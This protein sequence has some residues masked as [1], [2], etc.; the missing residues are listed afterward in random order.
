MVGWFGRLRRQEDHGA[1]LVEAAVVMPLLLMLTLG[2]WTTARAWNVHNVLDHAA[3]EAA[4][5]GAPTADPFS[6]LGT[7]EGEILAAR[8][9]WSLVD[10]CA[11]TIKG[12]SPDASARATGGATVQ[13]GSATACIGAVEDPTTDNRMQ[14]TVEIP[15]YRLDFLFFSFDVALK[16]QAVSRLEPGT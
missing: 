13:N 6:S 2:I 5:F 9:D 7:A 14:V 16:A 4:R 10:G 1:A 15:A 12:G 11:A 8:I 3:R